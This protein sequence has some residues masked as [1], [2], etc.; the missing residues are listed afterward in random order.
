MKDLLNFFT[1]FGLITSLSLPA[2]GKTSSISKPSDP[3]LR[4]SLVAQIYP[5]VSIN[6]SVRNGIFQV[7]I[8]RDAVHAVLDS[9]LRSNEGSVKD[10]EFQKLTISRMRA[11]LIK[12]NFDGCGSGPCIRSLGSSGPY[13]GIRIDGNFQAKFREKIGCS[14]ITGKCHFTPWITIEGEFS[15]PMYIQEVNPN[16]DLQVVGGGTRLKGSNFIEDSIINWVAPA[17]GQNLHTQLRGPISD[18]YNPR[19]ILLAQASKLSKD[20]GIDLSSANSLI[21]SNI[22]NLKLD[23]ESGYLILNLPVGTP[24]VSASLTDVT[25]TP[26]SQT[27]SLVCLVNKTDMTINYRGKWSNEVESFNI[28]L[29]P[30]GSWRHWREN[31]SA[32]FT[33]DFDSDLR[34]G[35]DNRVSYNLSTK[36]TTDTQCASGQRYW[37]DYTNSSKQSL[38]LYSTP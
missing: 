8:A 3:N 30:R 23:V 4:E 17:I 36:E 10:T 19:Q 14:R 2:V 9:I 18:I 11:N 25:T 1:V 32:Q 28:K 13:V 31:S 21:K 37:F 6:A 35:Q 24:T 22:G 34:Q 29:E 16:G 5:D 26:G 27:N 7:K 33:V 38:G 15:Q 12:E 20:L